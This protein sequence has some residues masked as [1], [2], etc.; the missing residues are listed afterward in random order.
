VRSNKYVLGLFVL[1]GALAAQQANPAAEF[2]VASV[3]QLEDTLPPGQ[4][5][6]S[7]VGTAGKPFKI[8]GNSVFLRSTLRNLIADAYSIKGYQILSLPS[9]ADSVLF[10]ITAKTPGDAEPTQDQVRPMLQALLAERFQLRHHA[11]PKE[12]SVYHLVQVKKSNLFHAASPD[13]TFS[14]KL[15]PSDGRLRSTATKESIG[16]F[17][18]LVGVSTDKPVIDKTGLSGEIDYDIVIELPPAQGRT[19]EE[20]N[21]QIV[22]AVVDQLGLKLQATKDTVDM[23]VVDRVDK[24]SAN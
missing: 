11:E 12:L 22:Y 14:W 13:E 3:K 23:L 16:D 21:R 19:A 9:W 15:T 7:F 18:R 4:A 5:D 1:C 6:L 20:L 17:V 10:T 2:E 8:T 24:P